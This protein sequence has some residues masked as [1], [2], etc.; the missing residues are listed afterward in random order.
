MY[1]I[2]VTMKNIYMGGN[3]E[4]K[5]DSVNWISKKLVSVFQNTLL[6]LIRSIDPTSIYEIGCGEG[7]LTRFIAESG[8]AITAGDLSEG[9]IDYAQTFARSDGMKHSPIEFHV[10]NIYELDARNTSNLIVCCE[11]FEHLAFPRAAL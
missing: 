4:N 6:S 9:V 5:Y 2:G 7:Y 10:Q 8:F 3:Y 11:V 1:L